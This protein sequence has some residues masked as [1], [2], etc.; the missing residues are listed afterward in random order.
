MNFVTQLHTAI[1]TA[2]GWISGLAVG[3]GG[4]MMGYH[5]LVRNFEEDP[6]RVAH[7]NQSM[8]KI[9]VG[10]AIVGGAG[11]IVATFGHFFGL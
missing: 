8:K 9:L 11:G 5:G 7:H 6:S 2:S 3:G 10:T 4:A 1:T